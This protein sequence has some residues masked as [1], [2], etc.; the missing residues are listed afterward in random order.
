MR[1]MK[2][3]AFAIRLKIGG[4]FQFAFSKHTVQKYET[5]KKRKLNTKIKKKMV[6]SPL[7]LLELREAAER[8]RKEQA[9][10]SVAAEDIKSLGENRV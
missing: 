2:L 1:L 5:K 3:L 4:T 7:D 9:E 8:A 6:V 10:C